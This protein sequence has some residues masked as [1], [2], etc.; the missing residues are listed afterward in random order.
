MVVLHQRT[1]FQAAIFDLHFYH[2][3]S[4]DPEVGT[5]GPDISALKS[6]KNI[7]FLDNTG[8]EPLK[9]TKLPSQHSMLGHHRDASETPFTWCFAGRPMMAQL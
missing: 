7:G 9:I 8:P 2:I 4:A 1:W 6:C 5:G 3:A